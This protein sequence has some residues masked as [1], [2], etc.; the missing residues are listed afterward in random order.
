[1]KIFEK[2]FK[3][4]NVGCVLA[5]GNFDG[6]HIGHRHLLSKAKSYA[7]ANGLDFG[8]YTFIDSPKFANA[9]HS[10][11]TTLQM[12]LSLL[13]Y[14]VSP[15]FVYLEKF[16][17]VK[18]M[19]PGEFT[20]YIV[21][22]FGCKCSF[23]GENFRFGKCAEGDAAS[24]SEYMSVLGSDAVVV[25]SLMYEGVVVSSTRIC[26]LIKEG[27]IEEAAVLMGDN[28][29]FVSKVIHGA[30]LGNKLG[31]PTVNQLIPKEIV[32]PKYGVYSTLV[33]ADGNE[34]MGV[35]NFGVKP[36]VSHDDSP[37]A[38][39]Y[40]I[41]FDSDVYDKFIGIYFVKRLRDE[42]VFSSLD[43]LRDNIAFNVEQTRKF[44]EEKYENI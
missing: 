22:K 24:L 34:Y 8:V 31:F 32:C 2:D 14:S 35:T 12:R 33:I 26:S 28:Y 19:S 16:D 41:D 7:E 15:D 10:V 40:I 42:M 30:H 6:V 5:F 1:M 23:C 17:D 43:E 29:G 21:D 4:S 11:L 9:D 18:N 36:T 3:K 13:D 38:E 20:E 44:F 39:T 25:D 27:M 37:V